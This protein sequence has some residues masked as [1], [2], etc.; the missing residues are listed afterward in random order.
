MDPLPC[1]GGYYVNPTPSSTNASN[2][3]RADSVDLG[4]FRTDFATG[5]NGP[6]LFLGELGRSFLL[7]TSGQPASSAGDLS[8]AAR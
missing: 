8:L 4:Y 1:Y 3:I 6:Y 7:A 5:Q 2:V